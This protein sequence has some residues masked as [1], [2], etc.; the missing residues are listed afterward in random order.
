MKS[1]FRRPGNSADQSMREV[2][3]A[4]PLPSDKVPADMRPYNLTD[5]RS[6]IGRRRMGLPEHNGDKNSW[7]KN[8][9]GLQ[10]TAGGGGPSSM[11]YDL[12]PIDL[13]P[14]I[15]REYTR[16]AYGQLVP[17][18][19]GAIATPTDQYLQQIANDTRNLASALV[20]K[21][22]LLGRVVTVTTTPQRIVRAD[23]LRGYIFLNPNQTTGITAAGTALALASRSGT[24]NSSAIGAANFLEGHF[25]LNVTVAPG[26]A[27]NITIRLQALDPISLN[28]ADVQDLFIVTAAATTY[29]STG[30]LGLGTDFRIQAIV[31]GAASATFSVG[32][33]LKNGLIG[34]SAG[35]SQTIYLGGSS[36]VTTTSGF[37]LLNGKERAFYLQENVELWAV[38]EAS[39][40]FRI[41][42]L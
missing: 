30:Q 12:I 25:W 9:H 15:I 33:V 18:G 2:L 37:P 20:L 4:S 35:V 39:L 41:F 34:T 26:G 11:P 17:A 16:G 21:R 31:S 28:Y 29:A 40:P 8:L 19:E 22:G 3:G 38:A 10:G 14:R 27:D 5:W 32:Y 13:H 36:G 1:R 24:S 6:N 23:Y 42:E 7:V